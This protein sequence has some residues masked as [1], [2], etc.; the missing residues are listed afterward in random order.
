MNICILKGSPRKNG[1]TNALTDPFSSALTSAGCSVTAIDLNEMDVRSCTACRWCQKDWSRAACIQKDDFQ[2][3]IDAVTACDL[4]VLATPIYS[5]YCTPRMKAVLDRLV[6]AMNMYYG[7]KKGPSLWEGKAAALIVTCGYPPERGADLFEEG[8]RRYCRHSRLQYLGMLC[9]RHMGYQTIFMD[10]EKERH[11]ET[12]A[13]MV[14]DQMRD[15]VIQ[16]Q[17]LQ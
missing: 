10:E 7:D 13:R 14:L 2:Q 5:W 1:N 11:A 9:E 6:Y 16:R 17:E 4:L 15:K 12:F 8:M 3:I